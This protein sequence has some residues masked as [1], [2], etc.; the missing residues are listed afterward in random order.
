MKNHSLQL[1]FTRL[2]LQ[3]IL[4]CSLCI[5]S[6]CSDEDPDSIIPEDSVIPNNP[7]QQSITLSTYYVNLE[8]KGGT[9]EIKI[10]TEEHWSASSDASWL[11]LESHGGYGDSTLKYYWTDNEDQNNRTA[12]ITLTTNTGKEKVM[13]NQAGTSIDVI[14]QVV[15]TRGVI[16]NLDKE[17]CGYI[18]VTFDRPVTVER[19]QF[20]SYL[21]DFN[22][23]Y[24]EDHKT[25]RQ[26]FKPASMGLDLTGQVSVV[27]AAGT[28]STIG[29][30]FSFYQKKYVPEGTLRFT[31]LS[32]DQKSWWASQTGPNK[33]LQLSTEDGHVMQEIDMPFDPNYICYN[34]YNQKYYVM[35]WG[36]VNSL[37]M[38]DPQK[39]IV[40]ETITFEPAPLD[41]PQYPKIYPLELQF[42]DDG[43][44]IVVLHNTS[45]TGTTWRYLD[46]ADGNKVSLVEGFSTS[47]YE[48]DHLYRSYDGKKIWATQYFENY[49]PMYSINR[50]STTPK[51][52]FVHGKFHSD[53]YYAGGNLMELQF[54]RMNNKALFV[55]APGSQCVVDID[56]QTYSNV[57][58][59]EGRSS[60][61]E[62]DYSDNERSLVY[63]A[64]ALNH[65]FL[66]LDMDESDCL[67][68]CA[69]IWNNTP[70]GIYHFP[71]TEQLI[72]ADGDGIYFFD[73]AEIKKGTSAS[74]RGEL[75]MK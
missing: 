26:E 53:E 21:L 48:F 11:E 4:L 5:V 67:F 75:S 52:H 70:L 19:W 28:I 12:T 34:P 45:T 33:L 16:G 57:M 42:T 14:P 62:W 9:S 15:S 35:P 49:N 44:G 27:N 18:E 59:A 72:V 30:S 22:P 60:R 25:V 43:F 55:T 46:S 13:V 29:V 58:L 40:E 64:S 1:L 47:D 17:E 24:S 3:A 37:C 8:A 65:Y 68:Y 10:M 69:H 20:N 32:D 51:K 66:L 7:A 23:I 38:V 73:A 74:T 54:N 41:H 71:S 6:A 36:E 2:F 63:L 39:G 50:D 56:A 31:L 61:A